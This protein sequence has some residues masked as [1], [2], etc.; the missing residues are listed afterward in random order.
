M[1]RFELKKD[2]GDTWILTDTVSGISLRFKEHELNET[3]QVSTPESFPADP[4][5]ASRI[6]QA[7]GEYMFTYHYSIAFPVPKFE[8]RPDEETGKLTV[9]RHTPPR[10]KIIFED[11][12]DLRKA[13]QK[14]KAAAAFMQ[15]YE[16]RRNAM[17]GNNENN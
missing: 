9:I 6:M 5:R 8:I 15:G 10:F 13:V 3:Q 7:M 14:V 17:L 16:H 11:E 1:K 12:C 4:V 2:A